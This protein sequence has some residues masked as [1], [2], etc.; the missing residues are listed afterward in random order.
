MRI[1]FKARAA[2][3][4]PVRGAWN[5]SV[6]RANPAP[7]IG[8][9][10]SLT[11]GE[12]CP[13]FG[14]CCCWCAGVILP[15]LARCFVLEPIKVFHL[16]A[17]VRLRDGWARP[18]S[19]RFFRGDPGDAL[20]LTAGAA[21]AFSGVRGK[22]P[23]SCGKSSAGMSAPPL[24][25][26]QSRQYGTSSRHSWSGP[27]LPCA[28]WSD[29][30]SAQSLASM[31]ERSTA[32]RKSRR[33]RFSSLSCSRSCSRASTASCLRSRLVTHSPFAIGKGLGLYPCTIPPRSTLGSW[34]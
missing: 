33:W 25:R 15:R 8:G 32:H 20:T 12:L 3:R 24:M 26:W 11:C 19:L 5:V 6:N 34:R 1:V 30:K 29:S 2:E 14:L 16:V 13:R 31:L 10:V 27:S 21:G 4:L 9:A 18:A 28:C 23:V 7:P 17:L 22:S